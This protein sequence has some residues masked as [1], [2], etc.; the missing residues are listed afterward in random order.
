MKR[1]L[2]SVIN[3]LVTDQRVH[4][5]SSL[6]HEEGYEVLLIGRKLKNS[7]ELE[8]RPYECKRMK[9]LFEKGPLFYAEYNL[10]L[11]LLLLTNKSNLLFSNDLD[12]LLPNFIISKLRGKR[13][14]Y[15]S[16]EYFTEV[17]E[18]ID[19]PK[20]QRV[21]KWIESFV[22][23]RIDSMIT[24]NESI[25]NLFREKYQL[26]VEVI[27]NVPMGNSRSEIV[28]EDRLLVLQGAGI[29]IDRGG[30]ELVSAMEWIDGK[31]WVIGDG[32]AL[33]K[34]KDMVRSKSLEDKISF[35]GK[36]PLSELRYLTAKAQIGFSLDKDSN[37]N[38]RYSLPNK[39][40]DYLQA[41][42]AV[43]CS[44]LVEVNRVVS[45][46]KVGLML[47]EVTPEIIATK[48]NDLLE[49]D[50]LL[51]ELQ[52]NALLASKELTWDK[53]QVKLLNLLKN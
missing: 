10:R 6:L 41:S 44:D 17:P 25:A 33:P 3:D 32:D 22:L 20:V 15:D 51:K 38:Y 1:V 26:K 40:F 4:R 5:T 24:V 39:L 14:I 28:K 52:L 37:V 35:K 36:V 47:E 48:V 30:E 12:T 21:W 9:L 11:F 42:C 43:I 46:F 34:L 29:N 45:E 23:S 16:H 27:R 8:K 50:K 53:E 2:I 49:N 18:L 19:R 31:L 13:L 7:L